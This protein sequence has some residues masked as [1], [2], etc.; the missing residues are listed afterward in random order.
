MT[1][2]LSLLTSDGHSLLDLASAWWPSDESARHAESLLS[3]AGLRLT[4]HRRLQ[5]SFA[6]DQV[7]RMT[8]A[9]SGLLGLASAFSRASLA[10]GVA[11]TTVAL[12]V[13]VEVSE[14][15]RVRQLLRG[16]PQE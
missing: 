11:S 15:R 5:P 14:R 13:W 16:W 12:A 2:N 6:L 3:D 1:P 7:A 8:V 9:S 10:T 4:R